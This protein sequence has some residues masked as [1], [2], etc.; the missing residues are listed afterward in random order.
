MGPEGCRIDPFS[1]HALNSQ[2]SVELSLGLWQ[3]ALET[4]AR[5]LA[6]DPELAPALNGSAYARARLEEWDE[7]ESLARR[8]FVARGWDPATELASDLMAGIRNPEQRDRTIATIRH[9]TLQDDPMELWV[10]ADWLLLVGDRDGALDEIE[11]MTADPSGSLAPIFTILGVAE[12]VGEPRFEA[13][14]EALDLG[15]YVVN[16]KTEN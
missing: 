6:V 16:L 7:A 5:T 8:W 9:L 4:H 2:A 12:L 15:P 11:R 10:A 3:E 13:A 1:V 14:I